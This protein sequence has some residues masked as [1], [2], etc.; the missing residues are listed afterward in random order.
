MKLLVASLAALAALGTAH[1]ARADSLDQ[2]N[3]VM[4]GVMGTYVPHQNDLP[5]DVAAIG[6]YVSFTHT[7]AFVSLGVRLAV[8]Y[9][10]LPSGAAGQQVLIEPDIFVGV[11]GAIGKLTLRADIGMGPLFNAGE[12]FSQTTIN[13]ATLRGTAQWR[14]VKQ[15]SIEAFV[16][17]ALVVGSNATGA[18]LEFGLGCG[19]SL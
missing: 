15:V 16:G 8:A 1:A 6:H 3:Q 9:G 14:I 11:R 2:T 18:L 19:W 12:G 10:W 5:A 17:P 7:L 4:F 13:H